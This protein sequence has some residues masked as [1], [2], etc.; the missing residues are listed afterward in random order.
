MLIP[1][2]KIIC[3]V[4]LSKVDDYRNI[5]VCNSTYVDNVSQV[6]S[7]VSEAWLPA[8]SVHCDRQLVY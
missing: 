6:Q 7:E 2:Y 8:V 1:Q 4:E 5:R 3:T